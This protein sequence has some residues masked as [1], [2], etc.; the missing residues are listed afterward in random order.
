MASAGAFGALWLAAG[1]HERL[2]TAEHVHRQLQSPQPAL[3]FFSAEQAG[4]VEAMASRII[5]TTDTP[6]AR[7]AGVVY[8]MD[9]ALSTWAK[10][11]Q[12]VFTDG[13]RKLEED[14]AKKYPGSSRFS[15]LTEV[16]QDDVLRSIEEMSFFGTLRF[17]TLAGMFSLPSYGGNRD[18][19]GW[20]LI[21]Q[22]RVLDFRP[23]FSWYDVPANRRALLG[24]GE[25]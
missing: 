1:S 6:G 15:A 11:Q 24:E 8:F 23:P 19:V 16:Q 7:E 10:A 18:F 14:V 12:S 21:G 25:R 5:P 17:A 20:T 3:T 4:D 9:R 22:D 13:L 2:A